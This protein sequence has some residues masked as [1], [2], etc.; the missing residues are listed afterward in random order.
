MVV[1]LLMHS[2]GGLSKPTKRT[3]VVSKDGLPRP[4]VAVFA[5]IGIALGDGREAG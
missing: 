4:T 2:V 1:Y 3:K 5:M